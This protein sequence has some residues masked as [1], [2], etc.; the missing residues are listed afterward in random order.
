V[1]AAELEAGTRWSFWWKFEPVRLTHGSLLVR[2]TSVRA[3]I[4]VVEW[5]NTLE[6][7]EN[8][9]RTA[10]SEIQPPAGNTSQ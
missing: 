10:I 8:A 7:V 1:S 3:D 4:H 6:V 5:L 2:T 9:R